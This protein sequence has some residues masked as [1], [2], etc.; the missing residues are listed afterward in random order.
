M[1]GSLNV[2]PS[3]HGNH[4]DVV[5]IGGGISGVAIA[6]ECARGGKRTLILEQND[7]ASGTTSRSTRII[8]GGLRYLEHGELG[9]VR[10]CL[11]ERET[12][13]R[14]RPHLVRPMRFVLALPPGARHSALAIR[15][16][17][18]LYK[19]MGGGR[20]HARSV[21]PDIHAFEEQ[22]DRGAD[23]SIFS[24][25]DAQCEF[26]ELLVTEWLA[27]AFEAGCAVRNHAQVLGLKVEDGRVRGVLFR[28]QLDGS[29]QSLAATRI[30][31][32]TGP[33]S[34]DLCRQSPLRGS[35]QLVGGVRGSHIVL[36]AFPLMPQAAVYTEAA[37]GRPFFV[38]PW[39]HQLL[40]GT[41]EV[42]DENEPSRAQ[43]SQP[44]I[45][46]LLRSVAALFPRQRFTHGDIRYAFA[47][48]RPLPYSPGE[49]L[50]AITRKH[51]LHDHSDEG[52]AG[53]IS[54][55]GGKLTTAASLARQCAHLIGIRRNGHAGPQVAL[56]PLDDVEEMLRRGARDIALSSGISE[57]SARAIAEWHG[58][59][60]PA[61]AH[62]AGTSEEQRLPLC[63]HTDH[64]VAEAADAFANQH[65][66][67]LADVLLRRVPVALGA[68]WSEEC[69]AEA[70]Q[71]IG[72]VMRWNSQMIATALEAFEEER[73]RFLNPFLTDIR[74]PVQ[75]PS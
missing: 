49:S 36:P 47:G 18:W 37:D 25:Q 12:L 54:V 15:M 28:D 20:T 55:I 68:C 74:S 30:I 5:V 23:F 31:N 14:E 72:K 27:D 75:H 56:A 64:L 43:P 65:A 73:T 59:R 52:A 70:A 6:G 62:L 46:Y 48:I 50:A 29:E 7:F 21:Q 9:L 67:T 34:D 57:S 63:R 2:R 39:N 4:F 51:L 3:L 69:S 42:A 41:T 35:K 16:G 13:L 32:A 71:K 61:I 11:R 44:E 1:E 8:H 66:V 22:L 58:R 53:M 17:L 33:W 26:P 10:E 24:Y 45:E 38:I 60:A 19:A 40:V